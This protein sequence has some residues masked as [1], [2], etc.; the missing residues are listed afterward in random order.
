MPDTKPDRSLSDHAPLVVPGR[1]L[2]F[3]SSA[4]QARYGDATFSLNNMAG[5]LGLAAMF[6]LKSGLSRLQ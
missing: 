1:H 6:V 2:V 4:L 5:S 3:S